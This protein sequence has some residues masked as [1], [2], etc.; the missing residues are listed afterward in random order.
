MHPLAA[1][2][3]RGDEAAFAELYDLCADR[4]FAYLTA[5]IGSR[6][7]AADVLQEVFV[8][9]VESRRRFRKVENPIGYVFQIARNEAIRFNARRKRHEA[10]QL[11]PAELFASIDRSSDREQAELAA[12][13]LNRIAPDE[14]ELVELKIFGGL[15]FREI[16]EL[17]GLPQA[18]V[19][20]TY[21]R[22]LERLRPWLEKQFS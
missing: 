10:V 18:T 7:R 16:A 14:R 12:A 11:N 15:T 17:T 19:A 1:R 6:D 5:R 3:A 21:R 8:R 2:L 13:A 22:A 9:V 4:L 20:T